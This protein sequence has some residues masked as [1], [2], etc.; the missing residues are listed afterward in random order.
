MEG[1]WSCNS[2]STLETRVMLDLIGLIKRGQSFIRLVDNPKAIANFN[3][4][5]GLLG[6]LS[7]EEDV[8]QYGI[9]LNCIWWLPTEDIRVEWYKKLLPGLQKYLTEKKD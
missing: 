4:S 1:R 6:R 5:M 3:F 9:S 8:K 7:T 2:F